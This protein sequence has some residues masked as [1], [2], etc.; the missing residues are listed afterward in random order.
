MITHI[1]HVPGTHF[2]HF[3]LLDLQFNPVNIFK[4]SIMCLVN[5]SHVPGISKDILLVAMM[6]KVLSLNFI[7]DK[8]RYSEPPFENCVIAC[9]FPFLYPYDHSS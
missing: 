3:Y 7:E 8:H 6:R 1:L 5:F 4:L 9:S 2:K